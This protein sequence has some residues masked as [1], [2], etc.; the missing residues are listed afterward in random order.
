MKKQRH[1]WDR[2]LFLSTN[3]EIY[4]KIRFLIGHLSSHGLRICV[5]VLKKQSLDVFVVNM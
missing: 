4:L 3:S 5:L 2:I 1:F